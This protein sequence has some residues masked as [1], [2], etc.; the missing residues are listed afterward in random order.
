MKLVNASFACAEGADVVCMAS[1]EDADGQNT[2][3]I[4]VDELYPIIG[5]AK[6]AEKPFKPTVLHPTTM[7]RGQLVPAYDKDQEVD[8]TSMVAAKHA[9][10]CAHETT[11]EKAAGVYAQ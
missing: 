5:A 10:R 4:S 2:Q 3:S 1:V 8:D 11:R 6:V 7:P 9:V